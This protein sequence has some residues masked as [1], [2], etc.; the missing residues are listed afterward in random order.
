MKWVAIAGAWRKT[1]PEIEHEVRNVVQEIITA[2]NGIVSGGALG[3]DAIALD[4]ALHRNTTATH[5]KIL[6][7]CSLERYRDE[8]QHLAQKGIVTESQAQQ[9]IQQLTT[10]KNI[11]PNALIEGTR[12]ILNRENYFDRI[13]DIID[14]S[15]ELVAFH[16]NKS[17]GTQYTID[18]A[19]KKGISVTI[20]TYTL[21]E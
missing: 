21:S 6:I 9:L 10:L 5:I 1:S 15:D 12:N 16:V 4:E 2:G 7:P 17:E 3:V 13:T 19:T 14:A 11:N 20:F 8:Y 18:K